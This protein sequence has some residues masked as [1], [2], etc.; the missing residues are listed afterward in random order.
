MLLAVRAKALFFSWPGFLF[1][2]LLAA[3]AVM[4]A[5]P[6]CVEGYFSSFIAL[7]SSGGCTLGAATFSNFSFPAAVTTGGTFSL[8]TAADVLVIPV[9]IGATSAR[10]YNPGL[11]FIPD[12]SLISTPL[13]TVD[14]YL[15]YTVSAPGITS[16]YQTIGTAG[17]ASAY[18]ALCVGATFQPGCAGGQGL[19]YLVTQ[20]SSGASSTNFYLPASLVDVQT[21][22]ALLS[23]N[24]ATASL[25]YVIQGFTTS[26]TTPSATP[27]ADPAALSAFGLAL[28]ALA[29]V[30]RRVSAKRRAR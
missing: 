9:L 25:D 7:D 12:F 5:Q 17:G 8:E 16:A 20:P 19:T 13:G 27:E 2:I 30:R 3:P 14:Y 10:D 11:W 29:M 1:A 18:E 22:I 26:T 21:D 4:P 24:G 23:A 15:K 6:T 28:F